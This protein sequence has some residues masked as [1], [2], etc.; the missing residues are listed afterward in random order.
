MQSPTSRLVLVIEDDPD[1]AETLGELLHR[2]GHDVHV[3]PDGATGMERARTLRPE[4]VL[5]DIGLPDM[6]GYDLARALREEPKV[7]PKILVAI[8]GYGRPQDQDDARAAG[9]DHHIAKP[10]VVPR[11]Q[12]LLAAL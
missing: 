8:T 12:E 4:V 5:V 6:S 7:Q 2:W 10:D 11:L 1:V 3:A 9:F